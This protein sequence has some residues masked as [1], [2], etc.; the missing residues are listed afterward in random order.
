MVSSGE[1]RRLEECQTY[2]P[3]GSLRNNVTK[4][5][6][7]LAD[8]VILRNTPVTQYTRSR[9][10]QLLFSSARRTTTS[11]DYA[12]VIITVTRAYRVTHWPP[13]CLERKHTGLAWKALQTN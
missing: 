6:S 5:D 10:A 8:S 3:V 4:S 9:A 11:E 1:A 7:D 13:F 12:A 2:I